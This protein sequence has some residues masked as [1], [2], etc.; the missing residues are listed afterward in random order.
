MS[1]MVDLQKTEHPKRLVF[2]FSEL[3]LNENFGYLP[4]IMIFQNF[5]RTIVFQVEYSAVAVAN[6]LPIY[7]TYLST[8]QPVFLP[9]CQPSYLHICIYQPSSMVIW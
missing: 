7:A 4:K 5:L 6:Y 3:F 2:I 8:C 9:T 1:I